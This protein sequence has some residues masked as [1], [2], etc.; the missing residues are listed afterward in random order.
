MAW[1]IHSLLKEL[2]EEG[3]NQALKIEAV[4]LPWLRQQ[5]Q[6]QTL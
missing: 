2:P 1:C 4:Q 5:C 3:G 6:V